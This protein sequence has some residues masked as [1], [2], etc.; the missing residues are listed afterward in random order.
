MM[1][2]NDIE[3]IGDSW[4]YG[5]NGETRKADGW[6]AMLNIPKENIVAEPGRTALDFINN[7]EGILTRA[8]SIKTTCAII[9]LLGND[10]EK[11]FQD[12]KLT[13]EEILVAAKSFRNIIDLLEKDYIFVFTYADPYCG[14][15]DMAKIAVPI[16]NALIMSSC[17]IGT[18]FIRLDTVLDEPCF[19][20]TDNFHPNTY[21]HKLIADQVEYYVGLRRSVPV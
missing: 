3:V 11:A 6:T 20:N 18:Q 21:G 10:I 9:S 2:I 15:N 4:A 19:E 7:R 1:N 14:K 13:L 5:F 16:L 17:P 12:G 8:L